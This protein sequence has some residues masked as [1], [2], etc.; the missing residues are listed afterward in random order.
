MLGGKRPKWD[1]KLWQWIRLYKWGRWADP[2]C[3]RQSLW[4]R[5]LPISCFPNY[6]TMSLWY[7][8]QVPHC[9]T[10]LSALNKLDGEFLGSIGY[11]QSIKQQ[12]FTELLVESKSYIRPYLGF[13]R[14]PRHPIL[15]KRSSYKQIF[16]FYITLPYDFT[17]YTHE[18]AH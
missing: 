8:P 4:T 14:S 16:L 6:H 9:I 17:Y 1:L 18:K 12:V 11:N 7:N 15:P 10:K 13:K 3:R 5:R 2:L